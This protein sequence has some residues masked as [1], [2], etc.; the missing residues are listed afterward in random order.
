M[1]WASA[2]EVVALLGASPGPHLRT[3]I[4][5]YQASLNASL[6]LRLAL[7][8][9][10]GLEAMLLLEVTGEEANAIWLIAA[11]SGVSTRSRMKH[12]AEFEDWLKARRFPMERV[13]VVAIGYDLWF[14]EFARDSRFTVYQRPQPIPA[15]SSV[16]IF[17]WRESEE[18]PVPVCFLGHDNLPLREPDASDQS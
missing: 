13:R 1:E 11:F 2:E 17:L 9:V 4:T 16:P 10:S 18:G 7:H 8:E 12:L 6:C 15:P 3:D 5:N 14:R